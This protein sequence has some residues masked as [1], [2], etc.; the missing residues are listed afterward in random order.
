MIKG[1]YIVMRKNMSHKADS[2]NAF[3]IVDICNGKTTREYNS[4]FLKMIGLDGNL[5]DLS[6]MDFTDFIH[7]D[8]IKKYK[9]AK[10]S[11]S[12]ENPFENVKL[13]LITKN[14][15]VIYVNCGIYETTTTDGYKRIIHAISETSGDFLGLEDDDFQ[16]VS[17]ILFKFYIDDTFP[18]FYTSGFL[19]L[20]GYTENEVMEKKLK[21]TDIIEKD[22]IEH[23]VH[24]VKNAQYTNDVSGCTVKIRDKNS[25]IH[26]ISCSFKKLSS[27]DY[28]LGIANDVTIQ[29]EIEKDLSQ[30]HEIIHD[31]TKNINCVIMNICIKNGLPELLY[32]NDTF[33]SMLGYSNEEINSNC[34]DIARLF[35]H[36]DDYSLF[37]NS[38]QNNSSG[39]SFECRALKHNKEMIWIT[40]SS[41]QSE[42]IGH[43]SYI[44]TF[45]DISH[46]KKI[47]RELSASNEQ[48][49][50]IINCLSEIAFKIDLKE[51]TLQNYDIFIDKYNLPRQIENM[52]EG[53]I[54]EDFISKEHA[55][56]FTDAYNKILEGSHEENCV[57]KLGAKTGHDLWVKIS[58]TAISDET[59]APVMISGT[60]S[61]ISEQLAA[62][63]SLF[64]EV[65]Y[66]AL[67]TPQ[68]VMQYIINL[69]E[70]KILSHKHFREDYG[71][72]SENTHFNAAFL[73]E[74][75]ASVHEEEKDIISK[76][77]SVQNLWNTYLQGSSSTT[78]SFRML[79]KNRSYFWVFANIQF[80]KDKLTGNIIVMIHFSQ[81]DFSKQVELN[82]LK[83]SEQNKASGLVS[84]AMF[85][86]MVN[87]FFKKEQWNGGLNVLFIL[88]IKGLKKINNALGRDNGEKVV[89]KVSE[90]FQSI[91]SGIIV[92]KLFGERLILF[93][94]DVESY[95]E[96]NLTANR[97]CN[98]CSEISVPGIDTK[99]LVVH[100]GAAFAP[101][102]G[103]D[104]D[105]LFK[106][107]EDALSALNQ[108]E[109]NGCELYSENQS[110]KPLPASHISRDMSNLKSYNE[111]IEKIELA[112]DLKKAVQSGQICT[113]VQ[114]QYDIID[115][116]YVS[117][118]ALVRW[119]HPEK[120]VLTPDKF[121][122]LSEE[123]GL[124]SGIDLCVFEQV[125]TY[126]KNRLDNKLKVLPVA[127]N[128]SGVTLREPDYF[129]KVTSIIKKYNIPPENIEL[130]ITE[131]S[132]IDN[133]SEFSKIISKLKDF[134]FRIS[135]DDFGSGHSSLELLT[136]LPID[137]LKLG[138]K[139]VSRGLSGSKPKEMIRTITNMASGMNVKVICEGIESTREHTFMK[140]IGC[141]LAQGY[142]YGR[143]TPCD[144][145]DQFIAS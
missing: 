30:S 42:A 15:S 24:A 67:M 96:L 68:S 72:I 103:N 130:E 34:N 109:Q 131:S 9:I 64:H 73:N 88:E 132:I 142:L 56:A 91:R 62:E 108:S 92:G 117:L 3:Y 19:K 136:E 54:E 97:I 76:Q 121:I 10:K 133:F 65:N 84:K 17:T 120:G 114:P 129:G 80:V 141:S 23:F 61:N 127:V 69:N 85:R 138:R 107:A 104:F 126:I 12:K 135:L 18:D 28:Y 74:L 27:N 51:K 45:Q 49:A 87:E 66:S 115:E 31:I 100:T 25:K 39:P 86:V 4:Q 124:I 110:L 137:V 11:V 29:K 90:Y 94:K 111:Y 21:Y 59:G 144:D 38:I 79:N 46:I 71:K 113:Y 52:P 77:L 89:L 101:I 98:C 50:K 13:R 43:G 36:P 55:S 2:N 26:F 22:D 95:D 7:K 63:E 93:V 75:L 47:E 145:A 105:L 140:E 78:I 33:S 122:G 81:A 53:I 35:I 82:I 116:K 70:G 57:V 40:V 112:A 134:G 125:C 5:T 128:Q 99:S 44:C 119:N 83:K 20:I 58:L 48:F 1:G 32:I 123:N 106:K 14:R 143:P 41:S 6:D 37:I 8:D 118:E 60:V 102:H 16:S 139:I